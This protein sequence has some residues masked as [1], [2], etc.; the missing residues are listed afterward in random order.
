M[1]LY[2]FSWLILGYNLVSYNLYF[3]VTD[4][5]TEGVQRKLGLLSCLPRS[6]ARRLLANW[7]HPIALM[8]RAREHTLHVLSGEPGGPLKHTSH[9]N[10]AKNRDM[11]GK[12]DCDVSNIYLITYQ[13]PEQTTLNAKLN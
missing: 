9:N 8:L 6:R 2:I 13:I 3:L 12:L 5:K 1:R 10:T 7:P 4:D 11:T